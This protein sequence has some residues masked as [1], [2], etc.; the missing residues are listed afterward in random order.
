MS[1]AAV[2]KGRRVG[3][4]EPELPRVEIPPLAG[5]GPLDEEGL[6]FAVDALPRAVAAAVRGPPG[7]LELQPEA[8]RLAGIMREGRLEGQQRRLLVAV[9]DMRERIEAERLA[10]KKRGHGEP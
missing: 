8:H 3:W 1:A 9:L 7:W 2:C 5:L 6:Q 10:Q 4:V